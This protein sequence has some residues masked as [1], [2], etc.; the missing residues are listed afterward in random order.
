MKHP[1]WIYKKSR[2]YESIPYRKMKTF[3]DGSWGYAVYCHPLSDGM[4]EFAE[5]HH[6]HFKYVG[7]DLEVRRVFTVEKQPLFSADQLL[8][9]ALCGL[10][11]ALG[12]AFFM[13]Y[14]LPF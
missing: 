3:E 8:I 7:E 9:F 4:W 2:Q 6:R 5:K 11:V 1:I 12:V 10:S 14:M 13:D